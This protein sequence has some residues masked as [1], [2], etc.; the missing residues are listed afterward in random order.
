[1]SGED[2]VILVSFLSS[3]SNHVLSMGAM[4]FAGRKTRLA[5]KRWL[6]VG[7]LSPRYLESRD[8]LVTDLDHGFDASSRPGTGEPLL[9]STL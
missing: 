1:M 2:T 5:T 9:C 7:F 3:D 6:R 4:V 8:G